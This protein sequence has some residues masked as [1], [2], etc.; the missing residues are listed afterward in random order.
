MSVDTAQKRTLSQILSRQRHGVLRG[1]QRVRLSKN[2]FMQNTSMESAATTMPSISTVPGSREEEIP[3]GICVSG[4]ILASTG[5]ALCAHD[6]V[7]QSTASGC[8]ATGLVYPPDLKS[9]IDIESMMRRLLN[10][11]QDEAKRTIESTI[12]RQI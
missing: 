6:G 8:S 5:L 7:Q 9:M 2:P 3:L 4:G 1:D 10:D 11:Q 12:T